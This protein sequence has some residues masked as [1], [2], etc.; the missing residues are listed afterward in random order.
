MNDNVDIFEQPL[1]DYGFIRVIA[2]MGE[3]TALVELIGGAYVLPVGIKLVKPLAFEIYNNCSVNTY[4]EM[5]AK[6]LE[7]GAV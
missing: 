5:L 2:R 7:M 3:D 4:A 1:C 6:M